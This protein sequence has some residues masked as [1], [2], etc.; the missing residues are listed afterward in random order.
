[1]TYVRVDID[2]VLFEASTDDLVG[3][4]ERRIARGDWPASTPI[5]K[6]VIPWT[7]EGLAQ[8]IRQAF[9]ARDASRLEALLKV[10]EQHEAEH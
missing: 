10:L 9:Y 2:D 3:E 7:R 5:C 8:D 1:M 6:D 4:V